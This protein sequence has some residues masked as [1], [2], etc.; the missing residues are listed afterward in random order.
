[1]TI[2][3]VG[4]YLFRLVERD[5]DLPNWIVGF[6]DPALGIT[7]LPGRLAR[8]HQDIEIVGPM[9]P[10]PVDFVRYD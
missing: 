8:R 7:I 5:R 9:L 3:K 1:V 2:D 4:W 6:H 10:I